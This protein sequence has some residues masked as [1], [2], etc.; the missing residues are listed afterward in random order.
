MSPFPGIADLE[1]RGRGEANLAG[2]PKLVQMLSDSAVPTQQY[3]TAPEAIYALP[4]PSTSD[5]TA[6]RGSADSQSKR[7][8]LSKALGQATSPRSSGSSMSRKNSIASES[9]DVDDKRHHR[10]PSVAHHPTFAEPDPFAGPPLGATKGLALNRERLRA[11]SPSVSIV[12]EGSEEGSRL[13]RFTMGTT[14]LDT[15]TPVLEERD[16]SGRTETLDGP[17]KER[18]PQK[19]KEVLRRMDDLLAMGPD[20][21]ARPDIL[22]DPPRKLLLSTQIL[23]VVNVHVRFYLLFVFSEAYNQTAKDRFLFLFNDILVITKPLITHGVLA[24]LD[25]RFIVKSVVPLDQIHIS[26]FEVEPTTEPERHHVVNRFIEQFAADPLSACRYLVD[27]SNPKVDAVT[28][29][30]LI[31]KTPELNKTQIGHLLAGNE[32]L[33]QAFIDRFHFKSVQ[34]D[35]ALRMFLLSLRLPTDPT[36]C[37]NMLRL[38]AYRYYEANQE[39]ISYDRD[40]AADLVLATIQLNDALFGTF[41]F[42]LPNHAITK[43]I[44]ISAFR[45]K[46]PHVLVPDE[47]LAAIYSSIRRNRLVQA[48]ATHE[49]HQAKEVTVTPNR[50]PPKLTYNVWS[51]RVYISIPN[52]DPSFKI[53]LHGEGLEFDPPL[54]D[55]SNSM[56]ESFRVRGL[57]LGTKSVLFDRVGG[58]A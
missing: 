48:L 30:S 54:L 23:Q 21:P 8:W 31:F 50:L 7:S 3:V 53:K 41:G 55:F 11:A 13:T 58:N 29:A 20:D 32:V 43:D 36:L 22:D 39:I 42:A 5:A 26:G 57:T 10:L 4:L 6:K 15:K 9:P 44:F 46:D 19:S 40:L 56:E 49:A 1:T 45:S 52:P 12:P 2:P 28:L 35:D 25:M 16:D 33:A 18:L 24:N 17:V 47:L 14:R 37:E 51:D 34:I 38:F 27:R